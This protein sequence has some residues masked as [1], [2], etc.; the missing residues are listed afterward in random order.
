MCVLTYV[1]NFNAFDLIYA[2]KNIYAGP[3]FSTDLMELF[4]RTF[5]VTNIN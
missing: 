2:I 5:L 4:Y 3:E 1:G